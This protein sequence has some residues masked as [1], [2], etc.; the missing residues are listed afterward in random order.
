MGHC[1][2]TPTLLLPVFVSGLRTGQFDSW[3]MTESVVVIALQQDLTVLLLC[4]IV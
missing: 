1:Q 3:I 2:I 4:G